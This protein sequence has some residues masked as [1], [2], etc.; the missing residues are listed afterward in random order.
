MP[1]RCKRAHEEPAVDHRGYCTCYAARLVR[2]RAIA[3]PACAGDRECDRKRRRHRDVSERLPRALVACA[4]RDRLDPA[5]KDHAPQ[6]PLSAIAPYPAA[7]RLVIA[8]AP[9]TVTTKATASSR[10]NVD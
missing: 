9:E 1:T 7:T 5:D 3:T 8:Q 6:L 10:M 4:V 2:Q